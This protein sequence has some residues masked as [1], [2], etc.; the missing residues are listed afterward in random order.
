MLGV[1]KIGGQGA[2]VA[3]NSGAA[4]ATP[5]DLRYGICD[6]DPKQWAIGAGAKHEPTLALQVQDPVGPV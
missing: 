1:L 4:R 5:D 6:S 3:T 2:P